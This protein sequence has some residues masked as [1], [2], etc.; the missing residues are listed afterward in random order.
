MLPTTPPG[1]PKI[2]KGN[3]TDEV[4]D[5]SKCKCEGRM[6]KTLSRQ[7][8]QEAMEFE[9]TLHD[10]IFRKRTPKAKKSKR[11]ITEEIQSDRSTT[12]STNH[13][14][15]KMVEA[16]MSEDDDWGNIPKHYKN[17]SYNRDERD[18]FCN[19]VLGDHF[20]VGGLKHFTNYIVE[21]SCSPNNR[22][23]KQFQV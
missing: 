7:E 15:V 10:L 8:K 13:D 11:D 4:T 16:W 5:C 18:G 21:V 17:C 20:S 9:D 2:D 19:W 1:G 6:K 3:E 14:H 23:S 12:V 22:I